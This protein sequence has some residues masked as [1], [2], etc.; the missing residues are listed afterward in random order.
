[1]NRPP[2]PPDAM[3]AQRT[4]DEARLTEQ[5]REEFWSRID[6]HN[7][8]CTAVPSFEQRPFWHAHVSRLGVWGVLLVGLQALAAVSCGRFLVQSGRLSAAESVSGPLFLGFLLLNLVGFLLRHRGASLRSEWVY[9]SVLAGFS[10]MLCLTNPA[11][12]GEWNLAE[13]ITGMP[14]PRP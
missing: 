14:R 9:F 1:M 7:L 10:L 8:F 12:A 6:S 4:P 3:S 2:H 5:F 13:V 11:W